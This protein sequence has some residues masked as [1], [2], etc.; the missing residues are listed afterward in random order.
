M[1]EIAILTSQ[2]RD[3]L[4]LYVTTAGHD[5]VQEPKTRPK[6][7]KMHHIF[8]VE[9]GTGII[10][11]NGETRTVGEGTAIFLPKSHPH[12]YYGTDATFRTGWVTFDGPGVEGLLEYFRAKP[13]DTHSEESLHPRP[14]EFCRMIGQRESTELLSANLYQ[15]LISFF[16]KTEEQKEP[17]LQGA[18]KYITD[19][20][21]RDLSV[22]EIA[23][24]TGISPSLLYRLFREDGSTPVEYLRQVRMQK[25][26]ELLLHIPQKKIGEIAAECGFSDCAYF[27]KVFRES[28]GS[29]P[30][31][32]RENYRF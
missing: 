16:S 14:K 21:H 30:R 27:C 18:K 8:V 29:T 26:R 9:K 6:G 24:A 12:R 20:C 4:P 32:F 15:L 11:I 2:T 22:G 3:L 25:A 28:V 17:R 5:Y 1:Y 13:L 19:H 10:E 23:E 31:T 7:A